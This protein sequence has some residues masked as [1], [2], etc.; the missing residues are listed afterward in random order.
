[1]PIRA[2]MTKITANKSAG[3]SLIT[4]RTQAHSPAM[5]NMI[6]L[7]EGSLAPTFAPSI[8]PSQISLLRAYSHA[9]KESKISAKA[10]MYMTN[11]STM[12]Q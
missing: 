12:G 8:L 2:R 6:I 4:P 11:S 3:E 9:T 7:R 10:K 1:M 5:I